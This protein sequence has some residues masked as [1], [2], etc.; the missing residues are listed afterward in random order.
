MLDVFLSSMLGN[1]CYQSC[2]PLI[3]LT[4]IARRKSVYATQQATHQ[5]YQFYWNTKSELEIYE[6]ETQKIDLIAITTVAGKQSLEKTIRN[7][8]KVCSLANIRNVP[9]AIGMDRPLVRPAKH[10]ADIHGES[11]MAY[12][13]CKKWF[14]SLKNKYVIP[15]NMTI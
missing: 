15:K 4:R 8:L 1:R 7:A 14:K 2:L 3:R 11:G 9:L 12:I 6:C 5:L 13:R 10:A